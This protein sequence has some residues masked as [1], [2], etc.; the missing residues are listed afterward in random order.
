MSGKG[1]SEMALILVLAFFV[2]SVAFWWLHAARQ[3][4]RLAARSS[5]QAVRSS[6]HCVEVKTGL[7]AC[8]TAHRL[9]GVRYLSD[10]APVLPVS[11]C[12]AHKCT[13][14]Y[15]HHDDRRD[16][17]RRNPYGQ[18]SG[19]PAAVV[20]ERRSRIERRISRESAIRPSMAH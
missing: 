6:Y 16:D 13:C 10:E 14:R 19:T 7:H 3:K 20:S 15:V 8:E 9:G 11:G 18:W 4:R 12:T 5:R 1:G 2:A 17:D